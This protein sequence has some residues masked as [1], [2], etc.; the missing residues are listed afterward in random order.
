MSDERRPPSARAL[1]DRHGLRPKKSWGQNFLEDE[2]ARRRIVEAAALGPDD[3]VVEIG[4]GLGSLTS[5]LVH[6]A[7]QVV[8]VERD[9]DMVRVLTTELGGEP[10]LRIE[11]GDAM[12][13]DFVGAARAAGRPLVVVA[14]LPYQITSP[15]LFKIVAEAAGGAVVARAVLMVQREFAERMVAPPGSKTYGRLSVMV[16]QQADVRILFHVG[17]HAFVP[18]PAVTSTVFSL[19]PRATPRAPVSD[20]ALFAAVVRAAFGARRKMLRRALEPAFGGDEAE[21]ALAA[22][23]VEGTRRA[24]TLAI[25]DFA[26]IADALASA[27]VRPPADALNADDE[28]EG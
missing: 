15:L 12:A 24:E 3:A 9:P 8:A 6:A 13:F 18:R 14:N 22:A 27:G 20:R 16:Q 5:L 19:V 21:R 10:R 1:L 25:A 23:G 28:R 26:R 2:A 7:G 4:P 11:P 17:S